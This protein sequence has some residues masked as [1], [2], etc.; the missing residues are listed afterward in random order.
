MQSGKAWSASADE[1]PIDDP[2][3]GGSVESNYHG[4]MTVA[5]PHSIR[6]AGR[7]T[8]PLTAAMLRL[9][10]QPRTASRDDDPAAQF[11]AT[12]DTQLRVLLE[13]QCQLG[14][15]DDP[16][17]VHQMRVAIRRMRVALRINPDLPGPAGT[18]LRGEL[19]WLGG[20]LGVVR[21]LDVLSGRL[22]TAANSLGAADQDG[23]AEVL[24]A[25]HDSRVAGR[26]T[27][28][29][30]L[31]DQRYRNLLRALAKQV[32]SSAAPSNEQLSADPL[33][34]LRR[35]LRKLRRE[36]AAIGTYP[37]DEQLH[38]LRIRGKRLRYAAELAFGS[39]GRRQRK[40]LRQLIGAAKDLQEVLG[41]HHDTV[42]AERWLRES[43]V[44]R[45]PSLSGP[46][47]LVVG[48]LVERELTQR[49]GYERGW[50]SVWQ[51]LDSS[52]TALKSAVG[53]AR[54]HN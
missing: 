40:P 19:G 16:E 30:T 39:C 41:D 22:A 32:R 1:S 36:A 52:A 21:D 38:I 53:S 54:S 9:A 42:T 28:T 48:R 46:A 34:L 45:P 43:C 44:A 18:E 12:M 20:E 26:G 24:A 10:A 29:A 4:W 33:A 13:Q 7:G 50:R 6:P 51:E 3:I 23:A 27:L 14:D 8:R 35:P 5:G 31:D 17:A 15:I 2:P 47:L 37:T 25:L 11:T 49:A